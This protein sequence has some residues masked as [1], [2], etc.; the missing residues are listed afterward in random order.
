MK[1]IFLMQTFVL[2]LCITGQSQ[3]IKNVTYT[4]T[5]KEMVITYDLESTHDNIPYFVKVRYSSKT[6]KIDLKEIKGDVGNLVYAGKGKKIIWNYAKELVH[7]MYE[8][9]VSLVVEAKP[10][11]QVL[12]KVKRLGSINLGL[13]TIYSKDKT[14]AVKLYRKNIEVYAFEDSKIENSSLILRIPKEIK[15]RKNYQVGIQDGQNA[16]FSN[17]FKIKPKI[18]MGWK[19]IPILAVPIYIAMKNYLEENEDLPGPPEPK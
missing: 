6:R 11:M 7:A 9:E 15:A 18:G 17:S 4:Q 16:Y 13:D 1:H 5:V 14:Y 19:I 8:G 10:N 2:A 12:R 3:T